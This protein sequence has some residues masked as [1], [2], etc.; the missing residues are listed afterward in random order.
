MFASIGLAGA[1]WLLAPAQ[2]PATMP[3]APWANDYRQALR[4]ELVEADLPAAAA[5]Y[6]RV[7]VSR[8]PDAYKHSARYRLAQ[9]LGRL[10][11][12][13][14]QRAVLEALDRDLP[15]D[16]PIRRQVAQLLSELGSVPAATPPVLPLDPR[17]ESRP[18]GPRPSDRFRERAH[19]L[20]V[21]DGPEAGRE[22]LAL[23][24][25]A[26]P[27]SP[28]RAVF[29][30]ELGES[31]W[32]EALE[33]VRE[34][35]QDSPP[36]CL[37][38][39]C[40]AAGRIGD[41]ESAERLIDLLEHREPLV[42]RAAAQALQSLRS[43]RA[44]DRLVQLSRGDAD[45]SV[46]E[47]GVEA[48]QAIGTSAA[49]AAV[50]QPLR[51]PQTTFPVWYREARSCEP[52]VQADFH[53]PRDRRPP[54]RSARIG[55]LVSA[56]T[57]HAPPQGSLAVPYLRQIRKA[58]TLQRAGFEVCLLAEPEVPADPAAAGL[59]VLFDPPIEMH[60]LPRWPACDA[61]VI[62]Q[63]YYLPAE[64]VRTVEAYCRSGGQAIVCGAVGGGWCGDAV[65]WRR[66]AGVRHP[67]AHGFRD[68]AVVLSWQAATNDLPLPT[69][70]RVDWSAHRGG[71]FYAHDILAGQVLAELQS[72]PIWAIKTQPVGSGRTLCINWDIGLN[73]DGSRDEDQLFCRC[74]DTL[75]GSP[76]DQGTL[77]HRMMRQVRWGRLGEARR[78]ATTEDLG[79]LPV[80]ERLEIL[81][82]LYRMHRLENNELQGEALCRKLIG[83][84]EPAEALA[85][86]EDA[87][88]APAQ[89]QLA[90]VA[91]GQTLWW[92][93][94]PE[95]L[96][97]PRGVPLWLAGCD[98]VPGTVRLR[99]AVGSAR[100][101]EVT[102]VDARIVKIREAPPDARVDLRDRRCHVRWDAAVPAESWLEL[103]IGLTQADGRV[104]VR[105]PRAPA[106]ATDP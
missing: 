1:L 49:V 89:L 102:A 71:T 38:A 36:V 13:A 45:V 6:R 68:E 66:V 35:L 78:L 41:G 10:G 104:R 16:A 65:A 17:H 24:R 37:A 103:E 25:Q 90:T 29:L 34:A 81:M 73:T 32:P 75:L 57:H 30:E 20:A 14:E 84:G 69:L 44:V 12:A 4:L 106:P 60:P 83:P 7:V 54:G 3:A 74:V 76:A 28:A 61:V 92:R 97:S 82:Q 88:Q 39:A 27:G 18:A 56:M 21:A 52:A 26:A 80:A 64:V 59:S 58:W 67:H 33:A 55:V 87:R 40:T 70:S 63:V 51:D 72:P 101:A 31:A 86:L 96:I 50:R 62:D 91:E 19:A 99:V 48:L 8:A 46:R 5:M 105:M 2:V 9:V 15:G 53:P 47:A 42:R 77:R 85:A 23:Y 43:V 22:L 95:W 94:V 11:R 98:R 100:E 79:L 93:D